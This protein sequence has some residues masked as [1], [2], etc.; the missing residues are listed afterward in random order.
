MIII[1]NMLKHIFLKRSHY[2]PLLLQK[3]KVIDSM[4]AREIQSA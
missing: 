1:Y 4:A 2:I 3:Q